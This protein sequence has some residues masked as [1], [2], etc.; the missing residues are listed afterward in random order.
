MLT[1]ALSLIALGYFAQYN[2]TYD[3]N[4]NS[5]NLTPSF[6]ITNKQAESITVSFASDAPS[7]PRRDYFI[8]TK[9]DAFGNVIYN[10]IIDPFNAPND[11]FTNVEALA[12]TDDE[13]T[14][15]SGY[16]YPDQNMVEQPFLIK[17]DASGNVLWARIYFVNQNPIV[18]TDLDKISLC[19]VFNDDKENY[20]IVSAADSDVNPGQDVA[21]SVVKV[22]DDG[23]MIWAKKYYEQTGQ[24]ILTR[25]WPG[26]IEFSKKDNMFM[27][28]G[29]RQDATQIT[30]RRVMYF[31]G[32][33]NNGNMVTKFTTLASKSIPLDQDMVYDGDNNV[34]ATVFTHEKTTYV[35]GIS[36]L[37]GFITIDA[38]L[39]IANP[40]FL[41]HKEAVLHN[42]RSIS[43]AKGGYVLCSGVYD[44]DNDVH[45]PS[46][47]HVD[48]T[49]VPLSPLFR[50]NVKDDVYFGHHAITYNPVFGNTEFVMVN[51]HK[52]D[53]RMIRTDDNGKA[54]GLVKYEPYAKEYKAPQD[55]YKYDWK[56]QG[57]YKKYEVYQKLFNPDYRKCDGDGS[58]YRT[59]GIVA[60]GVISGLNIYPS[61]VSGSDARFTVVNETGAQVKVELFNVAGQLIYSAAQIGEGKSELNAGSTLNPGMYLMKVYRSS[62]DAA[63][64]LKV[65]VT[66]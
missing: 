61:V 13:G 11:G 35:Q 36:S 30:K 64:T 66:E 49:G 27:I 39:N 3:V 21:T 58:S 43:L 12:N 40:K 65:L 52:T 63:Q 50:Y 4:A 2:N 32:I 17:V 25:D 7:L 54:C 57:D 1:L 44:K 41:W 42:G 22:A 33:D 37:I 26:D 55:F 29:H 38:S 6:V 51:L 62:G 45:N 15:V 19:R 23:T 9:H 46:W 47:L 10:N 5:D 16:Y 31:F 56:E 20:F 8:L 53:L 24:F 48:Y 28:T 60:L 34:F 14:L 18:K 59:T